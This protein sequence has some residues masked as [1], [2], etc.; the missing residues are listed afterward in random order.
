MNCSIDLFR[1]YL[2]AYKI[3]F[4]LWN[5]NEETIQNTQDHSMVCSS[6][7]KKK[8]Q[9]NVMELWVK[10]K[11]CMAKVILMKSHNT[12]PKEILVQYNLET[13]WGWNVVYPAFDQVT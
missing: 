2:Q 8:N 13:A 4:L 9:S 5:V 3:R 6:Q 12:N 7:R 11:Y 10:I 1:M